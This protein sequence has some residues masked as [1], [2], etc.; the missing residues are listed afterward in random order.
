VSRE[1]WNN[2]WR[3]VGI[4]LAVVGVLAGLAMVAATVLI[5]V[6]FNSW[7]SNK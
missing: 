6:A 3:V 4:S 5:V 7:G 1:Q 2:V